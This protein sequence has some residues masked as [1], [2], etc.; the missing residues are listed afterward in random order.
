MRLFLLFLFAAM[1]FIS[2]QQASAYFP[3]LGSKWYFKNTPLDSLNNPVESLSFF[4]TDSFAYQAEYK[5]KSANVILSKASQFDAVPYLDTNYI[6]F[7]GTVAWSYINTFGA[8]DS[9]PDADS[10]GIVSFLA[11]F[12]GWYPVFN[13]SAT[14][15]TQYDIVKKDT[16]FTLDTIS[17]PIRIHVQGK[18]LLD[19]T[20]TTPAGTFACKRFLISPSI[21]IVLSP[22]IPPIPLIEMLDTI[23]IAENRWIVKDVMPSTQFSFALFGGPSFYLPGS[24]MELVDKPTSVSETETIL[25]NFVLQQNYPN[26]FNPETKIQFVLPEAGHIQIAIFNSMGEELTILY[27]GER[28]AGNH[29]LSF[30]AANLSSGIYYYRL[31]AGNS[32][33]TRKMLLLK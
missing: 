11:S 5:G 17:V 24:K 25:N 1:S 33:E 9:I 32:T 27:E 2:A 10:I 7:D 12:A 16:T 15:N 31:R 19:Q 18:R 13:F 23:W 30:N 26:P 20:I 22:V 29:E 21:G 8:A 4:R 14:L 28:P 3:A 6:N